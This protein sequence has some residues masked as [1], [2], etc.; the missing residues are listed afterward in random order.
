MRQTAKTTDRNEREWHTQGLK[1]E[2]YQTHYYWYFQSG[3][4][5]HHV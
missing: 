3:K 2:R 4:Y 5:T 1:L